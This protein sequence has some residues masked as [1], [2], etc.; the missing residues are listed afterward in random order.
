MINYDLTKIKAI[1]LDVDGVLSQ[2]TISMNAEGVPERTVN[3][4]DGYVLQLAVKL[5][6]IIAIVTGGNTEA[7]R[8]RYSNLGITEIYLGSSIKIN[9]YH[10]LLEKYQLNNDEVIFMGDDIP[11]YEVMKVCGCPCCPKD[12]AWEI[13][14]ISCY[15]SNKKG[16][17]GCV[18]D[19][20][21][22]VMRA[23]GKWVLDKTAFGW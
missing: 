16:G 3:I 14:D 21:E 22:Q 23:Q 19:V 4:K 9:V 17:R 8:K 2:E 20:M 1:M 7:I 13:K 10:Q 11:D 18:R 6:Y 12:A 15:I 5:G